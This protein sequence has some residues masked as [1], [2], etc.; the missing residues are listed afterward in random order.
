MDLPLTLYTILLQLLSKISTK[1]GTESRHSLEIYHGFSKD[2]TTYY[3]SIYV[4]VFERHYHML[5]SQYGNVSA[6]HSLPRRYLAT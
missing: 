1:Y 5:Q 6:I 2:N 3:R 4:T